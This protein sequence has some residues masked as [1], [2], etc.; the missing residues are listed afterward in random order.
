ML[1]E[2]GL[3]ESLASISLST[4]S[5]S[6]HN[7][8]EAQKQKEVFGR[9][10]SELHPFFCRPVK[11]MI[12]RTISNSAYTKVWWLREASLTNQVNI[13]TPMWKSHLQH[14]STA[15]FQSIQQFWMQLDIIS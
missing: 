14:D 3:N 4:Q 12:L 2:L 6:A 5:Q 13:Y 11:Y 9:S 15:E 8:H 1:R 7:K 10:A